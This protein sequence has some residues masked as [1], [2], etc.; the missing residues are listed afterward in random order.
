MVAIRIFRR[1]D[2]FAVMRLVSDTFQEDYDP[3]VLIDFY[4]NW[5]NGF[6][7]AEEANEIVGVAVGSLPAPNQARMLIL[8]VDKLWRRKG[9]GAMLLNSF[10]QQCLLKGVKLV[11]LEVRVTNY[12]AI[13]FYKKFK[14]TIVS[15]IPHYYKDSSD[16]YV[17][18]RVL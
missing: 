2:I 3:S 15:T 8:G 12:E 10:I 9:I 7:V 4:N 13:E 14:F 17:M 18:H 1:S 11:T 5:Q 16:G 6:L